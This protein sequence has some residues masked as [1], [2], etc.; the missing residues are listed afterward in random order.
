[1]FKF[2]RR[3]RQS[4]LR[5]GKVSR[6]LLY[7]LGEIILVVIGIL[8]ALQINDWNAARIEQKAIRNYYERVHV[9]LQDAITQV[10]RY[11]ESNTFLV[12][13]NRRTLKILA[14][15]DRDSIPAL[16]ETLGALGTSW[17]LIISFPVTDEFLSQGYLAKI[18]N[19]SIKDGLINHR[20]MQE[21]QTF[22]NS[23]ITGQYST[24][25]EPFFN[26]HLNYS[27]VALSTYK[28]GLVMGGPPID[29]ESLFNSLELW[30][31]AT[32]KLESLTSETDELDR[33]RKTLVKLDEQI[34]KE[35]DRRKNE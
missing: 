5:E 27:T 11:A 18:E 30:N 2:F 32:F 17:T 12:A 7:A 10:D 9:E 23:A 3:L 29:Y 25:I 22:I 26:T 19:D 24:T 16:R 34:V 15:G 6:Y 4:L 31:I 33:Y 21:Y 35:L 8:L 1:M 14:S 20:L 13:Q 28:P